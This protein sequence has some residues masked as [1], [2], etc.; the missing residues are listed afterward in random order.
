MSRANRRLY[1]GVVWLRHQPIEKKGDLGLP[2]VVYEAISI[3]GLKRNIRVN[4]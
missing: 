2:H 1:R 4:E 3:G